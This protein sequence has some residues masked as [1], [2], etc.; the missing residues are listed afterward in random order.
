MV[1]VPVPLTYQ[2]VVPGDEGVVL[3]VVD[4]VLEW[5]H[6]KVRDLPSL[7]SVFYPDEYDMHN[8]YI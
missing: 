3:G 1:Q 5:G 4:V 8:M 6:L 7:G 2:L